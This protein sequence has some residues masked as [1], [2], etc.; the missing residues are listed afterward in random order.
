MLD[1]QH[2]T[3]RY[4][5]KLAVSDLSLTFETGK[6]YA[7]LGPNGSGKTTLMKMIAGLTKQ[8]SGEITLDGIPVG[9]ETKKHIAYMPT[10]SYF[11]SYMSIADA[12]K[13]YADFFE[14]FD[15]RR[16]E[17]A[18][19][20]MELNPKDKIRTLS[21]G[22]NAK[23]RL[24]LTLS[25]DAQVM[26]FDE[27]LN[28]VDILTRKQVVDEIIRNRENG[29]T[30]IISTHLVDELNAYI[31]VAI[32]MKN[33]VL[34]RIGDRAALEEKHGSLTN[35]YLSIYGGKEERSMWK[36]LKYEFRR[37][38]TSLLTVLGV[39]A[40]LEMYF[41]ISLGVDHMEHVVIAAVLMM[42]ASYG[43]AVYI[44][45][46][47]VASYASELKAKSAYLIFMTPNSGLKIMGSKYLYT[48]VNGILLGG[49]CGALGALDLSL[50]MMHEDD[51][52]SFLRMMDI[53]L[54]VNQG[55]QTGQIVLAVA[56]Y[57]VLM[58]LSLLTF[59]AMAYF[60]ITL[61]HTLFRDKKWRTW[62]ALL[63]F[64]GVYWGL[65][66]LQGL[67]PNP[68]ENL[69]FNTMYDPNAEITVTTFADMIPQMVPYALYDLAIVL[70]SLFGCGWMLDKKV[71]L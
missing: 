44:F 47:G 10:E 39:I 40:V 13:Y 50:I 34:E 38:R 33:G 67:L 23:V 28:G 51:W 54:R 6:T 41:L 49:V 62:V 71:S 16:Y 30:M 57:L 63:I 31:D 4:Q 12:G 29:R 3:R 8:T 35:L 14:D 9:P 70:L 11:Y 24:A 27:P 48:F 37:A 19:Q 45:V 2:L 36:L 21:S 42:F 43:A 68:V 65:S 66:Y 46:R 56:F 22:M 32:F 25:R 60:A 53:F 59:F 5:N 7:L 69:V 61:S 64:I 15:E 55:V 18:L 1:I 26:M 58:L 20:R 52:Q 17:E